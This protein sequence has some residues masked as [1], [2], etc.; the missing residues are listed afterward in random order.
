MSLNETIYPSEIENE[1][2]SLGCVVS[3]S[4]DYS[5][6]Y[7]LKVCFCNH[8]FHFFF[9]GDNY[10]ALCR[11]ELNEIDKK[12]LYK[13]VDKFRKTKFSYDILY[14]D[15]KEILWSENRNE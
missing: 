12:L 10:E 15:L 4:P 1:L 7:K 13:N 2:I 14:S 8:Q 3:E 9:S 5:Y 11:F 6:S